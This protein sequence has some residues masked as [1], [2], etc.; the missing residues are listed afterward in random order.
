MPET[1]A[2]PVPV[3]VD[4]PATVPQVQ[5]EPPKRFKYWLTGGLIAAA[6]G[7]TFY[8]QPWVARTTEV[9]VE[10]AVSAPA[11]R[12]LAVNG[13]IAAAQSVSLRPLVTGILT[14]VS[15]AEGDG[16]A[17]GADL[18]RIDATAQ[19]AVVRQALAGLDAALVLQDEAQA[20]YA[21]NRAL[22]DNVARTVLENAARAVQSAA[23]E[24]ARMTA[25]FDAAQIRLAD[26]TILA[27][28]KG[29]VLSLSADQGQ[30][31]DPSTVLMVLADLSQLVVETDV[32]E[33]YAT[34]IETGQTATLQLTGETVL[35]DSRVTF[36]SQRVD[37]ATGGL[38][39]KLALDSSVTAPVGLTVTANIIIDSREAAITLPRAA[40][41]SDPQG[42]AAFVLAD[43][44]VERRRIEVID[45]PAARLIVTSGLVPGDVVI[46]D[47][48]GIAD[49]QA[50][51]VGHP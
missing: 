33:A 14:A 19:Q 35:R 45:W 47:A 1:S 15:V 9:T 12:V 17:M 3:L 37:E 4:T 39:I 6:L 48:T 43:G 7:L 24:V 26:F 49:G 51:S 42:M 41:V 23:Q 8:F 34:Q 27:P 28:V 46:A 10:T 13:R 44:I 38:A 5:S 40:I 11:T 2:H 50:V 31:V 32:D 30:S 18:A 22:E 20:T 25:V 21:R 16:V 29:T 36:L